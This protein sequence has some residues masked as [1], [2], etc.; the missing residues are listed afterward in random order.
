[1]QISA[2]QA[3]FL[4]NGEIFHREDITN[5]MVTGQGKVTFCAKVAAELRTHAVIHLFSSEGQEHLHTCT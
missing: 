5:D 3:M 1:M 2:G 4:K